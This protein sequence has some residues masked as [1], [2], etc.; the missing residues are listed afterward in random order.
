MNWIYSLAAAFGL[1]MI[2]SAQ[3]QRTPE[4]THCRSD[5]VTVFTC[6]VGKKTVSLCASPDRSF[7]SG[8]LQYRF[9][10]IGAVELSY[11]EKPLP[12]REAFTGGLFGGHSYVRFTNA[13]A[14]YTVYRYSWVG[15]Q[16]DGLAVSRGGKKLFDVECP[17]FAD[18]DTKW[19]V[20]IDK[21][22]LPNDP[23]ETTI[24]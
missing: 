11:P 4:A 7:S 2:T 24:P 16:A 8:S 15:S 5:E 18:V 1:M 22:A 21:D 20:A 23:D 12:P 9:G 14:T 3:A 13:G 19:W 6:P 17:N 10:R